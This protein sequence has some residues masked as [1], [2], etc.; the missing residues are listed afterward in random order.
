MAS[1]NSY[2]APPELS[3]H[4]VYK[5]WLKEVKIW[6]IATDV[7]KEK[8]AAMILLSL[9]GKARE[10]ALELSIEDIGKD[11]GSGVMLITNKLEELFKEDENLEAFNA[12]EKFEQFRRENDMNMKDFINAFQRLNAKLRATGTELPEGVLAYRLLKS[13]NLTYEQ[14]Q[15]AK[16]TVGTFT[17]DAMCKKLKNIFGDTFRS[18]VSDSA[19][20]KKSSNEVKQEEVMYEEGDVL[21]SQQRH[22]QRYNDR[23]SGNESRGAGRG[24]RANSFGRNQRGNLRGNSTQENSF[25]QPRNRNPLN[26]YTGEPTKCTSCGSIW[27]WFR[28]CPHRSDQPSGSQSGKRLQFTMFTESSIQ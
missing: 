25:R 18:D 5:D 10:A 4:K 2:R 16:A 22:P 13:A 20:I 14:E 3:E 23:H 9:K 7:K 11:D 19:E 15:L 12:Y 17:F 26:S 1:S 21:Y 28:N 24:V 8:Q 27:H 6:Q